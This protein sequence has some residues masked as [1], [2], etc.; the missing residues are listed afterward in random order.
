MLDNYSLG[1]TDMKRSRLFYDAALGRLGIA[2]KV[3]GET[4]ARWAKDAPKSTTAGAALDALTK[5]GDAVRAVLPRE[6]SSA[7]SAPC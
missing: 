5:P 2:A 6:S 1:V 4:F 7:G 3:R